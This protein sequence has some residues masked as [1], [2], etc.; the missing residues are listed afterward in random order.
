MASVFTNPKATTLE[1][2]F[3]PWYSSDPNQFYSAYQN[4]SQHESEAMYRQFPM[5]KMIIDAQTR[6]VIGK[7]LTPMSSPETDITGWDQETTARFTRQAEAYFRL[8]TG[9]RNFD[10]YGKNDFK[11]LQQIAFRNILI[12]GDTL[13]HRGFRRLRNK[14]TAPYLQLISGRMVTQNYREDNKRMTGGV[15]IDPDTG[16]ETA[17]AVRI[18]GEDLMDT[19]AT[20]IV[21]RYNPRTGRLEFDLIQLQKSDPALVR[22][23]P[24]LTALRGSIL[25]LGKYQ[26]NHLL[27]SIVQNMFSVFIEKEEDTEGPTLKNKLAGVGGSPDPIDPGKINLGAGNVVPLN[28]KEHAVLVQRQAQGEDYSK[29]LTAN[30]EIIAGACGLSAETVLNRYNAS[31]SASRATIASTEKNNEILREEFVQKFCEPVW[32]QVVDTGVLQGFIEAPGYLEDGV[33]RRAALATTWAG[34]T[35]AQVDPVKEVNAY[36]AAIKAG[37]CT[38]E[39]AIRR[40]YGMDVEE[41]VER[42]AK[43]RAD[44]E[45]HGINVENVLVPD[46]QEPDQEPDTTGDTDEEQ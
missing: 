25:G 43:E 16:R 4:L 42:L 22:G 13:V 37:L 27:Q 46:A 5:G 21:R 24:L 10:W 17:Y 45:R 3:M 28:P 32:E 9:S 40:L 6:M 26:D 33:I 31:F 39:Y 29:Y 38:H 18:I 14:S 30:I 11:Q 12:E 1:S 23:I 44:Y 2:G 34:P 41:V 7:G 19:L 20:R 8:V 35:P 36:I 15:Y